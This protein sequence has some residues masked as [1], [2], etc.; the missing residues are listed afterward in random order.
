MRVSVPG[1]VQL[2]DQLLEG[3][4]VLVQP[5]DAVG[6]EESIDAHINGRAVLLVIVDSGLVEGV[7]VFGNRIRP[8]ALGLVPVRDE[9]LRPVGDRHRV[10]VARVPLVLNELLGAVI[11]R[12]PRHAAVAQLGIHGVGQL[13]VLGVDVVVRRIR[14]DAERLEAVA[15]LAVEDFRGRGVEL[16]L[17]RAGLVGLRAGDRHVTSRHPRRL[18]LVA[19]AVRSPRHVVVV[20]VDLHLVAVG[21]G[22]DDPVG[23]RVVFRHRERLGA[24]ARQECLAFGLG[25]DYVPGGVLVGR[26]RLGAGGELEVVGHFLVAGDPARHL[27]LAGC[28][29]G[30]VR[31]DDCAVVTDLGHPVLGPVGLGPHGVARDEPGLGDRGG[32]DPVDIDIDVSADCVACVA[33]VGHADRD[34]LLAVRAAARAN[35]LTA[36]TR[37]VKADSVEDVENGELGDELA[38]PTARV[39]RA[40]PDSGSQPP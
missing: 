31:R 3:V 28:Q 19:L 11:H 6:G 16:G 32:L 20:G 7:D 33:R 8:A 5:V 21:I 18:D 39:Q 24:A 9:V 36:P 30:P 40:I 23:L 22:G 34:K 13:G 4:D 37:L 27:E 10:A 14:V 38:V 35:C 17:V 1:R 15:Q 12:F 2:L 25:L 29:F 26:G